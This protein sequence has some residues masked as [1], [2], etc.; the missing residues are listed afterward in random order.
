MS[1]IPPAPQPK[2]SDSDFEPWAYRD[3]VKKR[4]EYKLHKKFKEADEIRDYLLSLG[5]TIEVD[6][7]YSLWGPT[8]GFSRV[9]TSI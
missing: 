3:L 6:G 5:I 9:E 1:G 7:I 4:L 2:I 8:G